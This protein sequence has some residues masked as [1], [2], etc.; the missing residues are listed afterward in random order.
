MN[1]GEDIPVDDINDLYDANTK[2]LFDEI[3]IDQK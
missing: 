1:H 3:G 2:M